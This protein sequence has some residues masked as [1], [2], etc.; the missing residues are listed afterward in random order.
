MR[1]DSIIAFAGAL[2]FCHTEGDRASFLVDNEFTARMGGGKALFLISFCGVMAIGLLD[3][4]FHSTRNC[5][6]SVKDSIHP[7]VCFPLIN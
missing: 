6:V 7:L 1:R 2:P 5:C 3:R 4:S